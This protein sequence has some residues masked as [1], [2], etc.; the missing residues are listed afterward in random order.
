M[1]HASAAARRSERGFTL[2]ELLVVMAI[3][4]TLA[5]IGIYGIPRILRKSE[6]TACQEHLRQL[7][8]QFGEYEDRHKGM[9]DAS[10]PGFVF[11]LWESKLIDHT[12]KDAEILFCPS[13]RGKPP[14]DLDGMTADDID[15]TGPDQVGARKR[16]RRSD[17]NAQDTVIVCDRVVQVVDDRDRKSLPHSEEGL[18][19]LTL[20]GSSDFIEATQFGDYVIIGADSPVDKFKSMVP[21]SQDR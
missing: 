11:A 9:P 10:G 8:L 5:S 2:I 18:C 6:R 7:Y 19:Y 21:D 15:Y 12:S 1:A 13:L 17:K 4:A 16:L 20:G 14:A 3:I